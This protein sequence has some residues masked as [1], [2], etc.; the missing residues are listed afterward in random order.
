MTKI[1]ANRAALE[2]MLKATPHVD[3]SH[4]AVPA[5]TVVKDNIATVA[6]RTKEFAQ[7]TINNPSQAASQVKENAGNALNS[8]KD[9]LNNPG[10]LA[11]QAKE[12]ASKAFGT[13]K[14]KGNDIIKWGKDLP[15]AGKAFAATLGTV[16]LVAGTKM[17]LDKSSE[18]KD[19][20]QQNKWQNQIKAERA[21]QDH[22]VG[23]G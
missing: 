12:G 4:T 9:K 16:A 21:A 18:N 14:S 5:A 17:A 20:A 15:P 22:A 3:S 1:E 8:A 10:E 2:N 13:L 19:A 11:G 6:Q 7:N 23:I